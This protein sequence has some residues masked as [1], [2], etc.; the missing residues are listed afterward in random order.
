MEM[1]LHEGSVV[2]SFDKEDADFHSEIV[3]GQEFWFLL[4]CDPVSYCVHSLEMGCDIP[5]GDEC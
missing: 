3:R 2:A 5:I 1:N 4:V